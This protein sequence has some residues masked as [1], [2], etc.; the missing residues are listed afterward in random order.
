[1]LIKFSEIVSKYGKPRGIIHLG[2]HLLEER[3]DYYQYGLNN[4]IWIEANPNIYEN[5]KRFD[6]GIERIFNH[7]ISDVDNKEYNFNITN[8]GQSSSILELG[9]H[10]IHHP[11]IYVN[12]VIVL[13]SKRM[14]T[15]IDDNNIDI[16]NYN[17]LNIDI[18][19]AELLALKGFGE[20]LNSIDYIYTEVNSS[21]VYK[22]CALISDLDDYLSEY[23][24]ER[25]ETKMTEYEW[26]DAI[27]IKNKIK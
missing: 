8:N 18:Q 1:M 14:K 24:F 23:G 13:R 5:I 19:G 22:G 17:F 7:V 6:N 16:S 9:E 15:I 3:K 25:V 4:T 21:E 10:K 11:H 26:G 27:Y 12:D 2:A 20:Y